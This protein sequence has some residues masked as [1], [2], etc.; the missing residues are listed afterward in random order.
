[1]QLKSSTQ[2]RQAVV[3]AASNKRNRREKICSSATKIVAGVRIRGKLVHFKDLHA[4]RLVGWLGTCL[5]TNVAVGFA[6]NMP[7]RAIRGVRD[8]Q[9][10]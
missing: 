8:S 7:G 1:M 10:A 2:K 4:A 3:V 9:R 6:C 5:Q